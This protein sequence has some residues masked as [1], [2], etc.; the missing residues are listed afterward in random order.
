[1]SELL[2]RFIGITSVVVLKVVVVRAYSFRLKEILL[3]G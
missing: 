2:L 3:L 1:M